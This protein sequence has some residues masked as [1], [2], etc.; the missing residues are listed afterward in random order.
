[1]ELSRLIQ[2]ILI[3]LI[4]VIVL[5]TIVT[6]SLVSVLW[7]AWSLPAWLV[8]I[9]IVIGFLSTGFIASSDKFTEINRQFEDK[10]GE[11]NDVEMLE[12]L[13]AMDE[14]KE[15]LGISIEIPLKN[16]KRKREDIDKAV[17]NLSDTELLHL[18]EELRDG[19][20]EEEK[21]IAWLENQREMKD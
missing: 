18:K 15:N 1:M 20:I 16:K 3:V 13:N 11:L 6:L 4:W 8:L 17:R 7:T 5:L 19:N 21:L 2:I 9:L 10:L 14:V 12:V